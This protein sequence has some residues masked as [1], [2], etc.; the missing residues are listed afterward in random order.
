MGRRVG[1]AASVLPGPSTAAD[2]HSDQPAAADRHAQPDSERFASHA[3][4]ER[5]T[6]SL[7]KARHRSRGRFVTGTMTMLRS[8]LPL[9]RALILAGLAIYLILFALPAVFGMAAAATP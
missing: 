9:V 3:I 2:A 8:A 4:T 1:A 7:V 5:I 6:A